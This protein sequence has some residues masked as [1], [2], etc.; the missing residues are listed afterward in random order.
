M[1]DQKIS[2]MP[3]ANVP[4][5]GA[6]LVPMTQSGVNV[7][8]TLAL[9][10]AYAR[11]TFSN[12]GV[13]Q[14]LGASQTGTANQVKTL[15]MDTTDYSVNVSL[16]APA[17]TDIL[18]GVAGTYTVMIAISLTN[19]S[20]NFDNFTF[21]PEVNGTAPPGS[22]TVTS[23]PAAK[24]GKDGLSILSIVYTFQ[25]AAASTIRFKWFT[26]GGVTS[27]Y[28]DPG[29]PTAPIHPSAAGVILSVVQIA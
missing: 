5:S 14:Y 27:V 2:A 3:P 17:K 25:M 26:P 1:A 12:Y 19:S 29:S 20:A 11:A 6:C 18:V 23:C 15:V 16:V 10:G 22:S 28:T 7:S 13:F 8:T 4:L 9:M 21:W 24:G